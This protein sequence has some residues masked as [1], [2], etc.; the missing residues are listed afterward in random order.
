MGWL[1][2]LVPFTRSSQESHT[3]CD[4]G[5]FFHPLKWNGISLMSVVG[6][7]LNLPAAY[8]TKST[9]SPSVGHLACHIGGIAG[10]ATEASS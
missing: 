1:I 9:F 2:G 6:M 8:P 4:I 5:K 7:Q 10:G 3:L